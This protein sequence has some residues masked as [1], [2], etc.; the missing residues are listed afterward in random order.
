IEGVSTS[1]AAFIGVADK[2]PIPGT[3]LPTGRM[4]QPVMV[5]SLTDYVRQFGG[6]RSDAFLTYAMQAFFN[7]GGARLY[8]VRVANLDPAR[9]NMAARA[10]YPAAAA[11]PPIGSP[12]IFALSIEA[13]TEGKWGNK[14]SVDVADSS[15]NNPD[16]FKLTVRFDNEPVETYDNITYLASSTTLPGATEPAQYGRTVINSRSAYIAITSDFNRRPT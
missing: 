9:G 10:Q 7:N 3:I 5:T 14:I 6:F 2:G 4:A 8:I 12:P 13:L 16:N 15:D 11:S 1:T